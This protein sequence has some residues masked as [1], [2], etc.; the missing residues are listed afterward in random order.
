MT[1]MKLKKFNNKGYSPGMGKFMLALWYIVNSVF[2]INPL[3]PFSSIKIFLLRSFGAKIGKGVLI[4]PAVNIKYPWFLEIGD[5][6]WI[7][8]RVWI[9][10]LT[11][12]KLCNDVCLSQGSMLLTGNHNYKL[13]AFDLIA[14]PITIESGTWIGAHAVVCPGVTCKSHSILSVNSVATK[15]LEAYGVYQGNSAKLIRRR[16]ISG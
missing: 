16:I 13:E 10:N 8:E 7:G 11:T 1:K 6:C 3:N 4:K 12:V 5:D 14:Q 15:D 2:F 9:D